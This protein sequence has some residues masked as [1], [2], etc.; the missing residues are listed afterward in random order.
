[1]ESCRQFRG[2]QWWIIASAGYEN[3]LDSIGISTSLS[4]GVWNVIYG[5]FPTIHGRHYRDVVQLTIKAVSVRGRL[6]ELG[7]LRCLF[8]VDQ[9]TRDT[10]VKDGYTLVGS[11]LG[12]A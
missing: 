5:N 12:R 11:G 6:S 1:V 9:Q 7:L 8:L 3:P 4:R 2:E 10:S